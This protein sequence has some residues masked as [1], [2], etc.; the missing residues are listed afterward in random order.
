MCVALVSR[1]DAAGL[2]KWRKL[3]RWVFEGYSG[4]ICTGRSWHAQC[5][6]VRNVLFGQV[7]WGAGKGKER[8]GRHFR[9]QWWDGITILHVLWG[10]E[11]L[12]KGSLNSRP[13]AERSSD[14]RLGFL[15]LIIMLP[16]VCT[17][18]SDTVNC[19]LRLC[20]MFSWKLLLQHTTGLGWMTALVLPTSQREL[21][22][23][24]AAKPWWR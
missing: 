10:T 7:S 6:S 2:W 9:R 11:F 13:R 4:H 20:E 21:A 5:A 23:R 19:T 22:R 14:A 16:I 12:V 17:V 24:H 3:L 1:L 8:G 15:F 18:Q